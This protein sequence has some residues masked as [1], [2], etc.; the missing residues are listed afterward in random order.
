MTSPK[1]SSS[2]AEQ[3]IDE[4]ARR[5]RD[6]DTESLEALAAR[7]REPLRAFLVPRLPSPEDA[8]DVAQETL[9]R[10]F[11]R[12]EQYDPGRSFKTWLFT[13]GKRLA[14]NR[15]VSEERRDAREA[16][17]DEPAYQPAATNDS[18]SDIW[19]RAKQVLSDESYRAVWLRYHE[20]ASVK[21][22]ARELG[23]TVVSTKVMLFRARKRLMQEMSQ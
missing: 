6:G 18:D 2:T 15:I 20:D 8:E 19:A 11:S 9:V 10:A 1:P 5:A 13:I 17:A 22:V 16:Q 4:L 12:L 23:R 3:S 14:V 21:D 7:I